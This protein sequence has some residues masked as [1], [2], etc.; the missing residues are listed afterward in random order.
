MNSFIIFPI[1]C[2]FPTMAKVDVVFVG[3]RGNK[4]FFFRKW[5]V[6]TSFSNCCPQVYS[7]GNLP[8]LGFSNIHFRK[9][10]N[11]A[12]MEIVSRNSI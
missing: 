1:T 4:D 11:V 8:I 3:M 12:A 2:S 7:H 10:E 9:I 6:T 5:F